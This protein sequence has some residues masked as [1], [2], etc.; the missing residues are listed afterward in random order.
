MYIVAFT[1][2]VRGFSSTSECKAYIAQLANDGG[3]GS[4]EIMEVKVVD[5][6]ETRRPDPIPQPDP[7]PAVTLAA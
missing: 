5:T 1:G 6:F 4:Y 7:P 2:S 3:Y